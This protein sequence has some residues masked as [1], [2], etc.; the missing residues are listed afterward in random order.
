MAAMIGNDMTDVRD[1]EPLSKRLNAATDEL[2]AALESIQDKI[3]DLAL[4]V[5]IWLDG[6][7]D[8]LT[9][10]F[11]DEWTEVDGEPVRRWNEDDAA[12]FFRLI[13]AQELGYGR[14]SDGWALLVRTV[15]Y[16]EERYAA[17][18]GLPDGFGGSVESERKPLLRCSRQLRVHAVD[19][20]PKL[21]EQLHREASRVIDA[22]EKAKQI[23]ETLK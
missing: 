23:A 22:V 5:E 8:E 17:G 13:E 12:R 2:N 9:R 18:W 14:L 3:N 19:R 11:G 21:I 6:T 15:R 4:G 16:R 10:S 20:I 7:N 1:L